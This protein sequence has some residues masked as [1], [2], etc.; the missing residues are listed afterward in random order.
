MSRRSTPDRIYNAQREGLRQRLI[1]T[2]HNSPGKAEEMLAA[3][4]AE[5]AIRGLVPASP[6]FWQ[7]AEGWLASRIE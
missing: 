6:A 5:A 7:E 2:E 4:E 3:W 1:Q